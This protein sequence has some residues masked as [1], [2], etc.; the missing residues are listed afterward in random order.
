MMMQVILLHMRLY[1]VFNSILWEVKSLAV[2]LVGVGVKLTILVLPSVPSS[3]FSS[4]DWAVCRRRCT[5]PDSAT[6][7][8]L[9]IRASRRPVR[10]SRGLLRGAAASQSCRQ[11]EVRAVAKPLCHRAR[12][13]SGRVRA[14]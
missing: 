11:N 3:H 5:V 12:T 13:Q 1:N 14:R 7:S 8:T 4:A 10:T 2:M 6:I 9:C